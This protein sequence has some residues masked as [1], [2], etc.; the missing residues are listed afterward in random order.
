MA[1]GITRNS[2]TFALLFLTSTLVHQNARA[3]QPRPKPLTEAT[4]IELVQR[5]A[6]DVHP[7]TMMTV[8]KHESV[9]Q[10]YVIGVNGK[11]RQTFVFATQAEAAQKARE[12]IAAGKSI[13]M[14]LG[15]ITSA[16][17]APLKLTP[18]TVFDPC[19]NIAA[20]AKVLT[21]A[22]TRTSARAQ[23]VRTALDGA[24]SIYNTG[25]PARGIANGYVQSVRGKRYAVPSLDEAGGDAGAA[26]A[27]EQAVAIRAVEEPEPPAWD[28]YA[29]ARYRA[30]KRP[31]AKPAPAEPAPQPEPQRAQQQASAEPVRVMLFN[32]AL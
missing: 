7:T 22:Y 5:C 15:Q 29:Q 3:E 23:D 1:N 16:N 20:A 11:P 19:T 21:E 18:E 17:L 8:L 12:L 9:F 10:P 28:V 32:E 27:A 13:D 14:G 25:N 30:T 6:P 26:G 4:I 24:L 2:L 31:E